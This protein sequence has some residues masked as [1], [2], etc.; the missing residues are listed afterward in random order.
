MK[1]VSAVFFALR[2]YIGAKPVTCKKTEAKILCGSSFLQGMH[3]KF[4]TI[5]GKTGGWAWHFQFVDCA[6][7]LFWPARRLPA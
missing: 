1:A 7:L 5:T 3:E 2:R 6:R 4:L